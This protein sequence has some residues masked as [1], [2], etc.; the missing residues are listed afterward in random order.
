MNNEHDNLIIGFCSNY[1]NGIYFYKSY[2]AKTIEHAKE[3]V[4]NRRI[5][6]KDKNH[7]AI[8]V[9][10]NELINV[11]ELL[12]KDYAEKANERN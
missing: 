6:S 7:C 3:I 11:L 4:R 10:N 12:Q 2:H 9:L 1:N 5:N 8:L